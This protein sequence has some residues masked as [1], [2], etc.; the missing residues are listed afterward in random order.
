MKCP[1]C[2]DELEITDD[3]KYGNIY[4]CEKCGIIIINVRSS[5]LIKRVSIIIPTI[6]YSSQVEKL[7]LILQ[8]QET[9]PNEIIVVIKSLPKNNESKNIT[10]GN[11]VI[12]LG[13]GMNRSEACNIGANYSKG[14]ILVFIDDDCIPS[15]KRWLSYLIREFYSDIELG[16]ISGRIIVPPNSLIQSFIRKMNGIGTPYYGDK[17]FYIQNQ[18]LNFSGT[19]MA[20]RKSTFNKLRGFDE[21]LIVGEDL[22][23]CIRI[24]QKKIKAK[25][26]SSAI[27]THFHRDNIFSL[28]KHAWKTGTSVIGF[29]NKYGFFNKF[30]KGTPMSIL[31]VF[32][33]PFSLLITFIISPM[34]LFFLALPYLIFVKKF[35]EKEL[36]LHPFIF[37][38]IL[39]TYS[40]CLGL[41][42]LFRFLK[43]KLKLSFRS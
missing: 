37:P 7:I 4:V 18:F 11:Q 26:V 16:L 25:Y 33:I 23:F 42:F 17:D 36:S 20:V 14:E 2:G 35:W 13:G 15:N 21:N 39:A 31:G 8:A 1:V 3:P 28:L 30:L 43:N 27:I 24:Y 38:T 9:I 29:I 41:G 10:F 6:T 12:I 34:F 40:I 19:N 5:S 22:D 32:L